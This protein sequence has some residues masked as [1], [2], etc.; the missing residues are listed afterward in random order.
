MTKRVFSAVFTFLLIVSASGFALA[1]DD[2]TSSFG[3]YEHVF[4]IGLDGAGGEIQNCSTPCFDSIFKDGAVTYS[5]QS[6]YLTISAQNWG[7]ILTGVSFIRHGFTNV[8]IEKHERDSGSANPS[9]FRCIRDRFPDAELASFCNWAPV[10]HGII[11]NDLGVY[12]FSANSDLEV[13]QAIIDYLRNGHAP[14]LMFVQFDSIDHAGH[15]FGGQTE[16]YYKAI[17]N[18]DALVGMIYNTIVETGLMEN[19][20]FI[21]I[22]DHGEG[23]GFGHGGRTKHE[24]TVTIAL[25]GGSVNTVSLPSSTWNRD[26]AAIAL[27]AL[28]IEQPENMT[29]V[30]PSGLFGTAS[31][32]REFSS[33]AI[34]SEPDATDFIEDTGPV[35]SF[36][37][38][39]GNVFHFLK[40][41]FEITRSVSQALRAP[42]T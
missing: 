12:K 32:R 2:A 9:L 25:A 19:S 34:G 40:K 6:E 31:G 17:E 10:N 3:A 27:F 14:K 8:G 24:H 29:A 4:I 42:G 5:G 28:G 33:V 15:V 30:L 21:V 23:N 18:A 36:M 35:E 7:S 37:T 1:A 39:A 11:E 38:A 41:V 13:T 20:L 22:S 26:A 16:G